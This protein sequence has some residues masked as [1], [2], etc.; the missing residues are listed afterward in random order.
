MTSALNI[1]KIWFVLRI[2]YDP[3]TCH[4]KQSYVALKTVN[5]FKW[6][7]PDFGWTDWA[8]IGLVFILDDS[9]TR[10]W[11]MKPRKDIFSIHLELNILLTSFLFNLPVF[12]LALLN[13]FPPCKTFPFRNY[14][15]RTFLFISVGF[16]F[17]V[18]GI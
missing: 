5:E 6:L 4:R 13:N 16:G 12:I 11:K 7:R 3:Q 8:R 14:R 18:N 2:T 10:P 9:H 15:L 17:F 1:Y